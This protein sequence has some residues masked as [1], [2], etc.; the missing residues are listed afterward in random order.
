MCS[1]ELKAVI[2]QVRLD[3][4]MLKSSVCTQCALMLGESCM[5][6]QAS[7][8][9]PCANLD[10]LI[11]IELRLLT[12]H[13]VLHSYLSKCMTLYNL[14][15]SR[16]TESQPKKGS[17]ILFIAYLVALNILRARRIALKI[18]PASS[19]ILISYLPPW[20]DLWPDLCEGLW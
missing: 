7:L 16:V 5:T 19:M 2:H 13:T 4:I 14:I 10:H 1:Q 9:T 11:R 18:F 8:P 17:G 20:P 12:S 3:A 15:C 6:R